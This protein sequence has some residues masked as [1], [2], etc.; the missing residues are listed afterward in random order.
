[1]RR[2]P[3]RFHGDIAGI[4]GT[5]KFAAGRQGVEAGEDFFAKLVEDVHY[6]LARMLIRLSYSASA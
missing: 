2:V 5:G 1:M 4:Q 6:V 3:G